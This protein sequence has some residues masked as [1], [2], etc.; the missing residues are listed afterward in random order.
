MTQERSPSMSRNPT[1]RSSA[2]RSPQNDRTA[3]RF[4]PPELTVTTRKI[5][6]RVRG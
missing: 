4:A 5:A 1:A 6:A 3:A 2:G